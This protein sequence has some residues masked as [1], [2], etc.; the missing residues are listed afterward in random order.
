MSVRAELDAIDADPALTPPLKR[1]RK[2]KAKARAIS[3]E[4]EKMKGVANITLD[5]IRWTVHDARW[6]GIGSTPAVI[7]RLSARIAPNGAWLAEQKQFVIID[8]PIMVQAGEEA[9]P[10][11]DPANP[12]SRP[13]RPVYEENLVEAAKAWLIAKGRELRNA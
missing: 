2:L 6:A 5:G 10:D 1:E 12:R 3:G 4:I 7:A 13:T 9:N 11:H 8:P